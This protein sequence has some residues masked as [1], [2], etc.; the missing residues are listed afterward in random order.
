MANYYTE[1][2]FV[3]PMSKAQAA[4]A[5]SCL[6]MM[7][8]YETDELH[9]FAQAALAKSASEHLSPREVLIRH[10]HTHHPE[11][12]PAYHE[13]GVEAFMWQFDSSVEDNGLWLSHSESIDTDAASAFAQACLIAYASDE[14][15]E[16]EAG[17]TCDKARLDGFGGHAITVTRKDIRWMSTCA[18]LDA[19]RQAAANQ[20]RYFVGKVATQTPSHE[21]V[22]T[23]LVKAVRDADP[24]LVV[25]QVALE[26]NGNSMG[27]VE[28]SANDFQALSSHLRVM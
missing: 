19:E 11:Y 7:S 8:G 4:M 3:I 9:P 5:V 15:V 13:G 18:F 12:N 23:F 20:E 27:C 17:H 14:L 2:S 28:V 24:A 10:A 26:I 6:E 21:L 16:I 1:A 22:D 25:N